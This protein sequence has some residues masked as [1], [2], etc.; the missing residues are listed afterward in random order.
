[1]RF[2]RFFSGSRERGRDGCHYQGERQLTRGK[3]IMNIA[4]WSHR[5]PVLTLGLTLGLLPSCA[6]DLETIG[7]L[8]QAEV[9][10]MDECG[11]NSPYMVT[12]EFVGELH[13]YAGQSTGQINSH[14]GQ[15]TGFTAP[16]GS[17]DYV[18]KV[19]H[20]RISAS[21][22]ATILEGAALIGG[23]IAITN[24]MDGNMVELRIHNH[25]QVLS[26]TT[27]DFPVDRYVLTNWDPDVQMQMPI[28][29]EAVNLEEDAAWSVLVSRE[30]YSWGDKV[31]LETGN[32]ANGWF[33]LTCSGN[34]LYKMKM[35]GYDPDSTPANPFITGWQHRQAT[36]KMLTADYCG[37]GTAF[38]A[39]GTSLHWRNQ[40]GWSHNN[41]PTS[42]RF[43][44][45]WGPNGAVC[46]NEPRLGMSYMQA[47]QDECASVGKMLPPCSGFSGPSEWDSHLPQ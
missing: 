3:P 13:L 46:L 23:R 22:G 4:T 38:T 47:I 26:W 10:P 7:A 45:K 25:G 19:E 35:M 6:V 2:V 43:E 39:D 44:A 15:V 5:L 31:V 42:A 1:M 29:T 9:C 27:P 30:L 16:D 8:G 33:N 36:V 41:V 12:G 20:G 34:S 17:T 28:C 18:V 37:T 40:A 21:R 24:T 14:G 11:A 32:N